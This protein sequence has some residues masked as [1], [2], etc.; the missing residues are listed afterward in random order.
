MTMK[1]SMTI[2]INDLALATTLSLYFPIEAIDR[3]NPRKA[4]FHFKKDNIVDSYIQEYWN[5]KLKVEP[6]QYFNQLRTIK[7]RLYDSSK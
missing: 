4:T 3:T 5:G 2:T 6:Q 1:Q 7:A